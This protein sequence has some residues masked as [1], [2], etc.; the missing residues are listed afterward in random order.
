MVTK[1]KVVKNFGCAKKGDIFELNDDETLYE[2]SSSEDTEHSYVSK[3]MSITNGYAELLENGGNLKQFEVE[4][5]VSPSAEVLKLTALQ[6]FVTDIRNKYVANLES[7]ENN[8]KLPACF[9]LESKT[10]NYNLIKLLNQIE[11]II[12]E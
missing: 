6:A 11:K 12:N 4:E 2:L 8:E 7:I 1:Y 5:E 9:K 10:V 3:Y